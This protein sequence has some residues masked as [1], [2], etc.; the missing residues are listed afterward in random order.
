VIVIATCHSS[1]VNV[2]HLLHCRRDAI[3]AAALKRS[4][5][6][7]VAVAVEVVAEEVVKVV[8]LVADLLMVMC[9]QKAVVLAW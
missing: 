5:V 8:L 3:V 9:R 7:A 2:M 1:L 4:V 6:A